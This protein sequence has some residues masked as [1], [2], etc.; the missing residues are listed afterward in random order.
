[1]IDSKNPVKSTGESLRKT[2]ISLSYI[3]GYKLYTLSLNQV[4]IKKSSRPEI[5]KKLVWSSFEVTRG[6]IFRKTLQ[7]DE[8]RVRNEKNKM[9]LN[10]FG[11]YYQKI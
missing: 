6:Q 11:R 2:T 8:W 7:Y 5:L 3:K 10:F 4:L 9:S 1:M